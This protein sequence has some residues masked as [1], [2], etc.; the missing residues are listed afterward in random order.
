MKMTALFLFAI[1]AACSALYAHQKGAAQERGVTIHNG[2]LKSQAYLDLS[3]QSQHAYVMGLLDG[4]YMAPMFGGPENYKYLTEIEGCVEGMKSSQV[5]AIIDK[6]I[7]EHPER[8]DW[9]AKDMS[10]NAMND[11]CRRR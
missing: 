10:Y 1:A 3:P 7:R 11:A 2:F 5:A 9:D 6:Y 8:W 4:W